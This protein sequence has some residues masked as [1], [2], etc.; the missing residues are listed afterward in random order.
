MVYFL[1]VSPKLIGS[2]YNYHGDGAQGT[3]HQILSEDD[4]IARQR[5][6]KEQ[7]RAMQGVKT[8]SSPSVKPSTLSES[9]NA[10][11]RTSP[12]ATTSNAKES[13]SAALISRADVSIETQQPS[14]EMVPS[15]ATAD[16]AHASAID[17]A[18]KKRKQP[19]VDHRTVR[20]IPIIHFSECKVRCVANFVS[21]GMVSLTMCARSSVMTQQ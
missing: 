3:S 1:D 2:C 10:G 5:S 14:A 12:A 21:H 4:K 11:I 16:E 8:G 7:R 15:E 6:R 19:T 13:S 18:S 9:A 17:D 20:A